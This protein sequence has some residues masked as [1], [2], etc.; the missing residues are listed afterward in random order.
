MLLSLPAE[1]GNQ[2]KKYSTLL[3]LFCKKL[4]S[5]QW[6]LLYYRLDLGLQPHHVKISILV[7]YL[8]L[9]IFELCLYLNGWPLRKSNCCKLGWMGCVKNNVHAFKSECQ[10]SIPFAS[11]FSKDMYPL[12]FPSAMHSLVRRVSLNL[13]KIITY[14]LKYFWLYIRCKRLISRRKLIKELISHL[15]LTL[16]L[17]PVCHNGWGSNHCH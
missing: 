17:W 16:N 15:D 14:I 10:V 7:G 5:A 12:I 9:S 6:F 8:K 3:L 11:T 4:I 1:D 2:I 13:N